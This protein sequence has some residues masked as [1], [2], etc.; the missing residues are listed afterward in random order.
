MKTTP[1][2]ILLSLAAALPLFAQT[3]VHHTP[4]HTVTATH[5]ASAG[6]VKLPELSSS[7]PALP[8]DAPCAHALF[9]FTDTPAVRL[10]YVSPLVSKELVDELALGPKTFE[11]D[12]IDYKV[13]TG[14]LAQPHMYYTIQYSG[15]LENGTKFDTSIGKPEPFVFPV[16]AHR[17]I[18]GWDLGFQGMRVGG[19]RRLFIPYQLAYGDR[20]QQV[21]PPRSELIFDVELVSQSATEPK[22]KSPPATPVPAHPATPSPAARPATPPPPATTAPASAPPSGKPGL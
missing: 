7:I 14:E 1:L 4:V 20:G 12:Y 2:L 21:I 8:A 10:D 6:C 5:T 11:L 16:G 19:K 13:G 15:Y 18:P 3:P 22:P 17:V 9:R